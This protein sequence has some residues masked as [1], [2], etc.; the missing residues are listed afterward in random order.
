MWKEAAMIWVPPREGGAKA[1]C[2]SKA[3]PRYV[4]R[5]LFECSKETF[6]NVQKRPICVSNETYF[7]RPESPRRFHKR[8]SISLFRYKRDLVRCQKRPSTV[9][10]ET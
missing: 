5:D 6:L 8:G 7:K 10:K 3:V 9:S 2:V 4:K 1:P